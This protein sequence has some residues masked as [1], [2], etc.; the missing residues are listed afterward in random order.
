MKPGCPLDNRWRRDHPLPELGAGSDKKGRGRV[1]VA[2]GST[3]SPGAVRLAAEGV[4]RAG[5]GKVRIATLEAVALQLGVQLPEAGVVG[6]P[7]DERG[8]I[9]LAAAD[10]LGDQIAQ[11]DVLAF[12]PGMRS[13]DH[14]PALLQ[15][16][17]E[18]AEAP[19]TVLLDSAAMIALR[20]TDA[21]AVRNVAGRLVLTPHPGELAGLL[22]I[23]EE[24]VLADM[25]GCAHKAAARFDAVVALKAAE[26]VIAAPDGGAYHYENDARGLGTAGSGD[27]LA[28]II[29]GLLA[30]GA[31]PLVATCWGVWLHGEAGQ[32]A[33]HAIGPFGFLARDVLAHVPMLMAVQSQR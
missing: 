12:G 19:R 1:L 22:D 32:A 6:L 26:T 24:A 16:A 3:L 8:E 10:R 29:A 13:S 30:R 14:L 11:A 33:A 23:E 20:E 2:G 31:E 28:G 5:A 15:T 21:A 7:G 4:L 25:P 27:V 17:L 9:A 18:A